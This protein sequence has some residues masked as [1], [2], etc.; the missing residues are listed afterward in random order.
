MPCTAKY[1]SSALTT[2]W[3]SHP[4]PLAPGGAGAT[5]FNDVSLGAND[6]GRKGQGFPA[7]KGWDAATGW[8]TPNYAEMV[9]AL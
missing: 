6:G 3:P 4:P 7:T 8:G 2:F 5:A 9:K 1:D